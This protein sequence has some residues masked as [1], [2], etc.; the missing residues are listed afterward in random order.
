ML[1]EQAEH[2]D[3]PDRCSSLNKSSCATGVVHTWTYNGP[4]LHSY[5]RAGVVHAI[6]SKAIA[7]FAKCTGRP[8]HTVD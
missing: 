8:T 3:A 6:T 2:M 7:L 5:A 4:S 1:H